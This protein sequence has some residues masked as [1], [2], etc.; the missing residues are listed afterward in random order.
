MKYTLSF[1]VFIFC[2]ARIEAQHAS[3]SQ[4]LDAAELMMNAAQQKLDKGDNG[5]ALSIANEALLEAQTAGDEN[6]VVRAH[7]MIFRVYNYGNDFY[8]CLETAL[9]AYQISEDALPELRLA[10]VFSLISLFDKWSVP[11]QSFKYTA[12]ALQMK[13]IDSKSRGFLL[14]SHALSAVRLKKLQVAINAYEEWKTVSKQENNIPE[15]LESLQALGLLL[16][17][18]QQFAKAEEYFKEQL[19]VA[20]WNRMIS[21]QAASLNNM[22][23]CQQDLGEFDA[24][25]NNFRDAARICPKTSFQYAEILMNRAYCEQ[26][27]NNFREAIEYVDEAIASA[28]K[29]SSTASLAK[30]KIIKAILLNTTGDGLAAYDE[31]I[32]ALDLCERYNLNDLKPDALEFL[33]MRSNESNDREKEKVYTEKINMLSNEMRVN[34]RKMSDQHNNFILAAEQTEK[35][36]RTEIARKNESR[37]EKEKMILDTKNREQGMSLME[38]QRALVQSEFD[39]TKEAKD[40]AQRELALAQASLQSEQ[41]QK[42]IVELENARTNQMLELAE[43]ELDR[44]VEQSKLKSSEQKNVLLE[45]ESLAQQEKV[46]S[47][48]AAQRLGYAIG[49]FCFLGIILSFFVVWRVRKSNARIAEQNHELAHKNND[50]TTSLK[51]ASYFQAAITPSEDR[52][53]Q[54]VGDGFIYYRPLDI[55]S[56]DLPFV[57]QTEKYLWVAAIDC[58]GHGVPAAMLTFTAYYSL[59]DILDKG[60]EY[61][62][63]ETLRVLHQEIIRTLK[64]RGEENEFNA[65]LDISLVRIDE[66]GQQIQFSGAQSPLLRLNDKGVEI[67]KGNKYSVADLSSGIDPEFDTNEITIEEGDKYF[68]LSDGLIHQMKEGE[69]VKLFSMKRLTQLLSNNFSKTMDEIKSMVDVAHRAWQGNTPQTDDILFI[70][71][72][73]TS[74]NKKK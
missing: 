31:C 34:E 52:Y 23:L 55:V 42:S 32:N 29:L 53:K 70:G 49:I 22:A 67:F 41:Q 2:A 15:Y 71:I 46:K 54:L 43:V 20:E 56:G 10:C 11:E 19:K 59:K 30:A 64:S 35:N 38:A 44:Q 51:S 48:Q 28:Q 73:L 8:K 72:E 17:E 14:Q 3:F 9:N 68:V 6:V 1:L 18:N 36:V 37:L 4:H 57:F 26:K 21:Q 50:I 13:D 27:L 16:K 58:I 47:A 62:T 61:N 7:L 63:G 45:T 39:R 12:E 65:G 69:G 24:A 5:A 74:K 25:K 33:R 66:K 60:L 40:K